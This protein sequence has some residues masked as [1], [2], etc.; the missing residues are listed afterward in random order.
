MG[1]A[2]HQQPHDP[3]DEEQRECRPDNAEYPN[4]DGLVG[5]AK[6]SCEPVQKNHAFLENVV[7]HF[8]PLLS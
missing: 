8:G 6:L 3:A 2:M 4:I 1:V 7:G 5:G